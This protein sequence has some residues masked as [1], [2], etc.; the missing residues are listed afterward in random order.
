MMEM[1]QVLALESPTMVTYAFVVPWGE[2]NNAFMDARVA[3]FGMT[4]A[5]E[6][7]WAGEARRAEEEMPVDC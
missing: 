3:D 1:R 2:A 6:E 5:D 7:H 4:R